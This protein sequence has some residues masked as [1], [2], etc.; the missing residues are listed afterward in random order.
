MA[1]LTS[2]TDEPRYRYLT[3][4]EFPASIP[5]TMD[6]R[7]HADYLSSGDVARMAGVSTKA[8]IGWERD[9]K[10]KAER[11]RGGIRLFA[12]TDVE[13]FLKDRNSGSVEGK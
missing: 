5:F 2:S 13:A 3:K 12:K 10:L 7:E 4:I 1:I 8:V 11:T 6:D 9:G